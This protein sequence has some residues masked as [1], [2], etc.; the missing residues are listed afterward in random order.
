M[1][2]LWRWFKRKA[3]CKFIKKQFENQNKRRGNR[4]YQYTFK[5][6]LSTIVF[7]NIP[8]ND[9]NKDCW[10]L[11]VGASIGSLKSCSQTL[12]RQ[13][14]GLL[15]AGNMSTTVCKSIQQLH[16]LYQYS[17]ST[18]LNHRVEGQ[19]C[20]QG[21]LS[22]QKH[23][24]NAEFPQSIWGYKVENKRKEAAAGKR[25]ADLQIRKF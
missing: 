8:A 21:Q 24:P 9:G 15:Y 13:S 5:K 14:T 17:G 6:H 7:E 10:Y 12:R 3:S 22:H 16:R 25:Y 20:D 11:Y 2:S 23:G 1:D 19:S 4:Y 18:R